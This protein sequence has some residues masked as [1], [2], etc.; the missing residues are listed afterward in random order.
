MHDGHYGVNDR[1]GKWYCVRRRVQAQFRMLHGRDAWLRRLEHI[2]AL[3]IV[4]WRGISG[5]KP[6]VLL[7]V[8]GC[9]GQSGH[10]PHLCNE[11]KL[12]LWYQSSLDHYLC[13]YHA[14]ERTVL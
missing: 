9:S 6:P 7:R 1:I 8:I 5:V 2:E 14:H 13:P 3:P 10:G 11:T 4:E 12:W